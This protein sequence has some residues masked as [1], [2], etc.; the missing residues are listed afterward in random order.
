MSA[1][2]EQAQPNSKWRQF[3]QKNLWSL[4]YEEMPR[5]GKST[6]TEFIELNSK[7]IST[8]GVFLGLSVFANN[9]PDKGAAHF[10]SFLL[11]TLGVLVF[12]ELS[13]NFRGFDYYGKIYWFREVLWLSMLVFVYIYAKMYFPFLATGFVW[14]VMLFAFL[15]T[16]MLVQALIRWA[17]RMPWFKGLNQRAR[18]QFIPVFGG[19]SLLLVCELVF[20]HFHHKP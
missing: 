2:Q 15:V 8:L 20:L 11:F 10:L 6:L 4:A 17:F 14:L 7:L 16:F 19:L 18:D 5:G 1:S 13:R 12:F 9:L 3:I